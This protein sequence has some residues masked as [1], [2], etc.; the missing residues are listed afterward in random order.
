MEAIARNIKRFR[1]FKNLTQEHVAKELKVSQ[2]QYQR[3][4]A[5][6]A[7]IKEDMIKQLADIFEVSPETLYEFD[8]RA[9]FQQGNT[10]AIYNRINNGD[11]N[12]YSIDNKIE[13]LYEDKIA[14]LED[15]IFAQEQKLK[16]LTK[17]S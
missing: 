15:K 17:A 7:K 12:L 6:D 9:V 8:E 11:I 16:S 13:K 14:L 3:I 1:E 10:H 4:E 5:G 2:S